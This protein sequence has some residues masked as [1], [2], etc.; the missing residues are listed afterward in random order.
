MSPSRRR[1]KNRRTEPVEIIEV[2]SSPSEPDMSLDAGGE[3]LAIERRETAMSSSGA[4]SDPQRLVYDQRMLEME[5][6]LLRLRNAL[7]TEEIAGQQ[8][9]Q[10]VHAHSRHLTRSAM[11]QQN[12]AFRGVAQQYEHASAEATEAAVYK[13]RSSQEAEQHRQL[14]FY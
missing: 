6:E 2:P 10:E 13:E 11:A 1:A 8:R 4:R 5:A 7:S 3:P 14:N 12:E 9:I